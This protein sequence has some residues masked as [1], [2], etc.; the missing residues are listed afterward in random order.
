MAT[1][2]IHADS[3]FSHPRPQAKSHARA[4]ARHPP[5][6]AFCART[7]YPQAC[8]ARGHARMPA[9]AVGQRPARRG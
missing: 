4:H 3:A 6:V 1:G 8:L 2:K 9:I 5:Q 7:R